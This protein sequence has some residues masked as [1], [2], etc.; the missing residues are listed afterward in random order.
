MEKPF[1]KYF[2]LRNR[3]NPTSF[4]L[5]KHK[6]CPLSSL[7]APSEEA[8][9]SLSRLIDLHFTMRSL[10]RTWKKKKKIQANQ[11]NDPPVSWPSIRHPLL[12]ASPPTRASTHRVHEYRAAI[13]LVPPATPA[14]CLLIRVHTC[15]QPGGVEGGG[16]SNAGDR[17]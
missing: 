9:P 6:N 3:I 7:F 15:C 4:T 2:H 17:R 1:G 14:V 10:D 11:S 16:R 12:H 13:C 5:S 8:T